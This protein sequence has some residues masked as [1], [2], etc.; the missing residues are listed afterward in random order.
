MGRQ[1][2]MQRSKWFSKIRN[3][4]KPFIENIDLL[5]DVDL[6]ST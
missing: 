5:V 1:I 4:K 3:E 6:S 2:G